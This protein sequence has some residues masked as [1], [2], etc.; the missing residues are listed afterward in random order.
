MGNARHCRCYLPLWHI[1]AVVATKK[2]SYC[3][4]ANVGKEGACCGDGVVCCVWLQSFLE[5]KH[6]LNLI[7]ELVLNTVL[8]L[9]QQRF[10]QALLQHWRGNCV[11]F[12]RFFFVSSLPVWIVRTVAAAA[13]AEGGGERRAGRGERSA[14]GRRGGMEQGAAEQ[15]WRCGVFCLVAYDCVIEH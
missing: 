11:H 15:C 13:A 3:Y 7:A 9:P 4:E 14:E 10:R 5:S 6:S 1:I 12:L 8:P 2:N